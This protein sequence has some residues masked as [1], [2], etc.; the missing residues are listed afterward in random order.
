MYIVNVYVYYEH[1][2]HKNSVRLANTVVMFVA[3]S[4]FIIIFCIYCKY[5]Q[6]N[7]LRSWATTPYASSI[8][9]FVV[10]TKLNVHRYI[11]H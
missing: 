3:S 5:Y 9:N 2:P 1:L 6:T 8:V 10:N 4:S 7:T 11:I